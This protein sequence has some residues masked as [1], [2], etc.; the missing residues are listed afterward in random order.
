VAK[1]RA[2]YNHANLVLGSAT[3]KIETYYKVQQNEYILLELPERINKKEMPNLTIVDMKTELSLGNTSIFSEQLKQE[4]ECVVHESNQAMIFLNRRGYSSFLRCFDCGYV[5]H[6]TDCDVS[7]VYHK[8][9]N[10]LKCHFC[11]KRYGVLTKCPECGSS[12]IRRGGI[13]TQQIVEELK[14][15]FPGVKILRMDN[16]T[17][18]TKNAHAKILA[19]FANTKPSILVGTQMIAKGHDFPSVTLV[20]I[21]D[22]DLSLHFSDYRATERTF[23][24]ITQVAGRAGRESKK[25]SIVLQTYTPKH[26]VYRFSKQYDYM[27]FYE[28]ELNLRK[29]TNFPPFSKIVRILV[30][31]EKER[32]TV[33]F[34]QEFYDRIKLVKEQNKSAFI[35][36]EA[37]KSPVKRIKN[38]F[39]YQILMRLTQEKEKQILE[40][41]FF[42]KSQLQKREITCFVEIDPQNLS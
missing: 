3:P 33:E 22:A 25:G 41:I 35:Y 16:D 6:C 37:M 27:G 20:G 36:L 15:V 26:Y 9:D 34:L 18:T 8:H 23:E 29:V 1:F 19:E 5:P 32:K 13:G 40:E 2:K 4:L 28:K 24:L 39:R 30:S 12:K 11:N 42:I 10:Q 17:T 14:Q 7:L 21:V 31:G 38:K